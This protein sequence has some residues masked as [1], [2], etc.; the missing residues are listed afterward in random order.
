MSSS[1][2]SGNRRSM[3][4]AGAATRP[5]RLP[6]AAAR[7]SACTLSAQYCSARAASRTGGGVRAIEVRC[8]QGL[9]NKEQ[10]SFFGMAD[11]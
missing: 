2:T 4:V 3:C 6:S 10:C 8:C 11:A 1:C 9:W 5:L 7:R